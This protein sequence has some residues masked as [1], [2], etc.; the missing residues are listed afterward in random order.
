MDARIA[1]VQTLEIHG[2]VANLRDDGTIEVLVGKH[3]VCCCIAELRT[4]CRQI[5]LQSLKGEV[6]KLLCF[7]FWREF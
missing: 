4:L 3:L 6:E 2:L 7:L 5:L 1:F